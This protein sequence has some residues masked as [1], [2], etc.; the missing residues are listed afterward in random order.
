MYTLMKM[1]TERIISKED[2][3]IEEYNLLN[4]KKIKVRF[5]FSAQ[6]DDLRL[7]RMDI[8]EINRDDDIN[9]INKLIFLFK[10]SFRG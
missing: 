2:S 3:W 7:Y 10:E 6:E 4:N 8:R 5:L 9:K 1:L